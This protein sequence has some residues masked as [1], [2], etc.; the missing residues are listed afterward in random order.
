MFRTGLIILTVALF[1]SAGL[2]ADDMP[3]ITIK[4]DKFLAGDK[5][6]KIWGFDLD[7]GLNLGDLHL[8]QQADELEFL[9]VNL[10]RLHTLDWTLRGETFGPSNEPITVGLRP[11]GAN[12]KST[13][14]LVN[15]DKF[16]RFLNKMREKNIY[17]AITLSVGGHLG[18]DDVNILK[19]TPED[20]K[21]WVEAIN[22]LNAAG[23]NLQAYKSLPV[24]DER[25]LLLRKEWAT[26]LLSMKNPQTGVKLA[27]DHQLAFLNTVNEN[28]CWGTFYRNATFKNL[29]PYFMN[30]FLA[31]WNRYLKEKY[32]TDAALAAA[33]TQAGKKGLLPGESLATGSVRAL[34]LDPNACT[35]AEKKEKIYALFSEARR[36]DFVRFTFELDAAHQRIMRDLYRSLGW[37]RPCGYSDNAVGIGP[38]TGAMWMKSDLMPYVE[39]HPYDDASYD[40]VRS[41]TIR[42]CSYSGSDFLGAGGADRPMWGSEFREG[43]GSLS[44][45]R[46][47][48]PM[49]AAVYHSL[50]GRDG[51]AW[52]CWDLRRD[53][54]LADP[55]PLFENDG[56]LCNWDYPWLYSYRA[57][58]R[59][60]RSGEIEPLPKNHPALSNFIQ[61]KADFKNNQIDRQSG[62]VKT[63]ILTVTT[64]SFRTVVSPVA[65]K[66]DFSD[67]LV[68]LTSDQINTIYIEKISA[69]RYEVTAVGTTGREVQGQNNLYAKLNP[70]MCVS[71]D[72][73]FKGRT[74]EK[75]EHIDYLGNALETVPGK[76]SVMPF[77][78]GVRLYRVYLK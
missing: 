6:F 15:V 5:E 30:K 78:Y 45:T 18:P 35:E 70:I 53:R 44:W 36:A 42:I 8:Q 49:Y 43:N 66:V 27:E 62:D 68:N 73:T 75:I 38:E 14:G 10:L 21:A 34:P 63:A 20:E 9:G 22:K 26:N 64:R 1:S 13:R 50:Q 39:E 41:P 77:V 65:R 46:I 17:V 67:V 72:V 69:D 55:M 24:I 23:P 47:P 4:G 52:H 28:S 59:L 61:W 60:F 48:M 37:T 51:L 3:M 54:M 76:K 25:A 56:F 12:L 19:T 71:G 40:V 11:C 7:C 58:G 2:A 32:T 29:P 31:K 57:A 16:Y 74:I 33:W